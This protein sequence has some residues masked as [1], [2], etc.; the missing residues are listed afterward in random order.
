MYIHF[1]KFTVRRELP[2]GKRASRLE[3]R[4][5]GEG[6][7]QWEES[8]PVVRIFLEGRELSSGKGAF[9]WDESFLVRREL[10]GRSG[11]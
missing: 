1:K 9:K 5:P 11:K 10:P 7:S 4:F 6:A 8:F 2:G 3:G